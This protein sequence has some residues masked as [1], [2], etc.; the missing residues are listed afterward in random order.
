M[1]SSRASKSE[2]RWDTG[3]CQGALTEISDMSRGESHRAQC[4]IVHWLNYN[5]SPSGMC[6][7]VRSERGKE[8]DLDQ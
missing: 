2:L 7:A 3:P 8:S 6:S 1:S 5:C 4:C